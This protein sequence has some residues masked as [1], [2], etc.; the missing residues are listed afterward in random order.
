MKRSKLQRAFRR[1]GILSI[2]AIY[3]LVLAGG[4]VRSTGSGMGCPDWP[5]CFGSWV[6]PTKE[7]QLPNDYKEVFKAKRHIKN[8]KLAGY[9]EFFNFKELAN[10]VKN[11]ETDP[12]NLQFN[13]QKTFIEYINRVAGVITGF[14]ILLTFLFSFS[15]F[16]ETW[17]FTILS[18]I[19][20]ILVAFQGWI[21]SLVVST[22]LLPWMVTVHMLLTGLILALLIYMV[23]KEAD[24]RENFLSLKT[25]WLNF[26]LVL[27]VVISIVQMVWGTQVREEIDHIAQ[28]LMHVNRDQWVSK[29]GVDFLIHRSF[30]WIVM[31]VNI[32]LIYVVYKNFKSVK[33]FTSLALILFALVMAEIV[34]GIILA[35]FSFPAVIQPIH[36]FLAFVI[37]GV[38]FLFL[39]I[40]NFK[41]SP[42]Y[43]GV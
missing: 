20:L 34:A 17:S 5:K 1:F 14:L 32:L 19:N 33:L 13:V 4:I 31:G 29:L 40:I 26:L 42:L 27:N 24:K 30:S 11:E 22:D 28:S 39:L 3:V 15:Y 9:L 10:Q 8:E 37:F 21:G 25:P 12:V 36:L 2:I 7:A 35:Y 18:F 38:Q 41:K 6:P 16:K 43:F 23:F